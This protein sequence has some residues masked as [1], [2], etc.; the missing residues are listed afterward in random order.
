MS[1][2]SEDWRILPFSNRKDGP[3]KLLFKFITSSDGYELYVTDLLNCWN[4]CRSR[5][6]I[7]E[8]AARNRSSI[9][10]S[11]DAS[12]FDVLLGK[13][14]DGLMGR[15]GA[16]CKIGSTQP[17]TSAPECLN[18]FRICSRIPL[19][20]PLQPLFWTFELVQKGRM[21]LTR[22]VVLPALASDL[23]HQTQI[24]D[25][26]KRIEEKDHV[27]TRLMD[28]I[29][30]SSMDLSLVFPGYGIGRKGLNAKQATKVVPGISKFDQAAWQK[31]FT[32]NAL[33]STRSLAEAFRK[34]GTDKLSFES[35]QDRYGG[36]ACWEPFGKAASYSKYWMDDEDQEPVFTEDDG[37]IE[38]RGGHR[39]KDN[40]DRKLNGDG[41]APG[42]SIEESSE[43]FEVR[44][45]KYA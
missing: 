23:K 14:R 19:P 5:V 4:D 27:I 39:I 24:K 12:Q 15:N 28:K 25:L 8:E 29:E 45:P 16:R 33:A 41:F 7:T 18:G 6:S 36:T 2:L 3:P 20:S 34:S 30:Q 26:N 21:L 43:A 22:E 32:D 9:D 44:P 10:P 17:D 35:P 42:L 37:S 31:D 11:E 38:G 13:L 40:L 1:S